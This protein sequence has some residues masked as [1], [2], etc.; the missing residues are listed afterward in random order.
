MVQTS[1]MYPFVEW[2]ILLSEAKSGTG[3]YPSREWIKA[4]LQAKREATHQVR[5][6]AHLCGRLARTF[7]DG[8]WDFKEMVGDMDA[9]DRIQLNIGP[10]LEKGDFDRARTPLA[11]A[12]PILAARMARQ[13][14]DPEIIIQTQGGEGRRLAKNL[15]ALGVSASCLFDKSGG[16]GD[17]AIIWPIANDSRVNR[18]G[19]AGGLTPDNLAEQIPL[20]RI[21]ACGAAWIDAETGLRTDDRFDMRKAWAFLRAALPHVVIH[22]KEDDHRWVCLGCGDVL[23]GENHP[24]ACMGNRGA[25]YLDRHPRASMH[26]VYSI[27]RL[28]AEEGRLG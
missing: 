7:A 17:L 12:Q 4:L 8:N 28:L 1:L 18:S 11:T 16:H 24:C 14:Y 27:G 21:S 10:G 19:Y 22:R 5:L 15:A 26:A 20:I 2:G 9:F 25:L 23:D 3:R 6:S 13:V